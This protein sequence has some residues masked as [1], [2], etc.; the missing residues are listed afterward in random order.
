MSSCRIKK[1][2]QFGR[3]TI[4]GGGGG[5]CE[6][7]K[8]ADAK[9]AATDAQLAALLKVRAEQD[10]LYCGGSS[11]SAGSVATGTTMYTSSGR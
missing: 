8:P 2:Q 4:V 9:K 7:E 3:E 10:A 6:A 5:V 1:W 11:A